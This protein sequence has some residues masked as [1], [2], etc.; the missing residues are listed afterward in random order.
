MRVSLPVSSV[1]TLAPTSLVS[2]L[3]IR[4]VGVYL[5]LLWVCNPSEVMTCKSQYANEHVLIATGFSVLN[6]VD[7]VKASITNIHLQIP[8]PA[9]NLRSFF[10]GRRF[11]KL[12]TVC[13]AMPEMPLSVG[14]KLELLCSPRALSLPK[15]S[16]LPHTL[17]H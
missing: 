1:T 2:T 10:G 7:A 12:L 3:K 14:S 16:I 6:I 11:L 13:F 8:H 9:A 4:Y 17:T 15:F 5:R